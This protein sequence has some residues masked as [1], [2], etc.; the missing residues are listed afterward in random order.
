[1]K[2]EEII[3]AITNGYQY[4]L[5][6]LCCSQGDQATK[7][8]LKSYPFL[9]K[10]SESLCEKAKTSP[11]T[12]QDAFVAIAHMA[13]GW[14]PTILKRYDFDRLNGAALLSALKVEGSGSACEFVCSFENSPINN[15]WVGLS[16]TLHFINP[17]FFPIWDSNVARALGVHKQSQMSKK[18]KYCDYIN[19]CHS[20]L[21]SP[22][23]SILVRKANE[24]FK[25]SVCY[26]D[27]VSDIRA[28]EFILFAIGK[29]IRSD[30][31]SQEK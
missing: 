13:Y 24:Y 23:A 12:S 4:A 17:K 9:L 14:M 19:L 10:A 20:I 7:V 29:K 27:E 22:N 26:K 15:S 5:N 28:L 3:Q 8:Y 31:R 6:E 11:G 25:N 16:K 18:Q 30:A 1:M 2:I 21:E